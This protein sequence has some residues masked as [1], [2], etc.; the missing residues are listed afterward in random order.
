[1]KSGV[2]GIA[3]GDLTTVD[4]FSEEIEKGDD[5]LASCVEIVSEIRSADGE[6]LGQFGRAAMDQYV[7]T[8]SVEINGNSIR[9]GEKSEIRTQYTE[10][11]LSVDGFVIVKN[12]GGIFALDLIGKHENVSIERAEVNLNSF[13]SGH[14]GFTPW[15][16]GFY[17][18]SGNADNGVVHG[19]EIW[20]DPELGPLLESQRK[21]QLGIDIE[22]RGY[23]IKMMLTESGYLNIYQPGDFGN[24]GFMRL[25]RDE[26]VPHISH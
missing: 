16:V 1:M 18:K 19:N 13:I 9:T 10:F 3:T 2:I 21:N 23:E 26:I 6:L 7:D 20:D 5:S 4:S 22:W 12:S 15:K 8:N 17:G 25:V 11:L 24:T 14:S